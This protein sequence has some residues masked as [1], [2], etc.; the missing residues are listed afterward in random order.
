M[1]ARKLSEEKRERFLSAALN[2]FVENGVKGTSTN[3]I[4]KE[5]GTAAG[6]LFLYFPTKQDL[7]D[8]LILEI[9]RQH[10]QY[11]DF[12]LVDTISAQEF[13]SIIWYGLIDWFRENLE[14]YQY[15]QQVRETGVV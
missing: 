9:Y 11:I 1:S 14:A 8:E 2:L 5:A 3:A 6:T 7:I 13:F 4:A 15:V 12:N 10:T